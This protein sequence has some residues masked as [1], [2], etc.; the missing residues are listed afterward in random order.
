MSSGEQLLVLPGS[1]TSIYFIYYTIWCHSFSGDSIGTFNSTRPEM[2]VVM[3]GLRSEGSKCEHFSHHCQLRQSDILH[4]AQLTTSGD[5]VLLQNSGNKS[6]WL[7]CSQTDYMC[8]IT[9]DL[10]KF[11]IITN[12]VSVITYS[13]ESGEVSDL[14]LKPSW[15][16]N[17]VDILGRAC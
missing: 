5:R 4:T 6:V 2:F 15:W 1:W 14:Q 12:I 17:S 13:I 7:R 10:S 3:Y 8:F 9:N 11:T 16:H